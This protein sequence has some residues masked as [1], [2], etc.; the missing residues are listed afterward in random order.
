MRRV[1]CGSTVLC[2]FLIAGM[3]E[4]QTIDRVS[5]GNGGVE[6]NGDSNLVS[7]KRAI[8]ADGRYVVFS[9]LADNLVPDDNNGAADVFRRDRILGTTAR[10]SLSSN[11]G[12]ALGSS[13]NPSISAN[14]RYVAFQ[15]DAW[16]IVAGDGNGLIDIFLR[17]MDL[18]QTVRA[19]VDIDG[20]DPDSNSTRPSIS[21]DGRRVAFS[22]SATDLIPGGTTSAV[23]IYV[24]DFDL[25]ETYYVSIGYDG[26]PG[27]ANSWVPA[28][29]AGRSVRGRSPRGATN[30]VP[31]TPTPSP[32]AFRQ[33][34]YAHRDGPSERR[35]EWGA[36]SNGRSRPSAISAD[37][38]LVV[39]WCRATDWSRTTLMARTTSLFRDISAGVTTR[40]NVSSG[41][42]QAVDAGSWQPAIS[43]SGRYVGFPPTR[44]IW[45]TAASTESGISFSTIG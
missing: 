12:D 24:R 38:N 22:S 27:N 23:D 3:T 31:V 4:A 1:L 41:G 45:S 10:V 6:G 7:P 42:D 44:R 35:H 34:S 43:T 21:A 19:S 37:G 15:S 2:V 30:L 26:A 9:S 36:D 32:D 8:S 5:E 39:W 18:G 14:G 20:Q 29:S 33:R 40:V 25:D 16:N 11:G 17:D 28:I 13:E